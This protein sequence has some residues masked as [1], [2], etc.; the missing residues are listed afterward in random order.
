MTLQIVF[1]RHRAIFTLLHTRAAKA[2]ILEDRGLSWPFHSDDVTPLQ[3]WR[4]LPADRLS[5]AQHLLLR[6]TLKTISPLKGR[7]WLG[8]LRGDAAASI[9]VALGCL[10]ITTVT[11][12]IDLAMSAMAAHALGGNAASAL[13]LSHVL[14]HA[15]LDYPFARELAASWLALNLRRAMRTK[16]ADTARPCRTA[17]HGETH[18]RHHRGDGAQQLPRVHPDTEPGFALAAAW[19]VR[20]INSDPILPTG[21]RA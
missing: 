3:W 12:E 18:H 6:A 1:N 8:G 2:A 7:E 21:G 17:V 11:L 10:P 15:P 5:D 4:T 14:R 19:R 20:A 16:V 13:V 9:A